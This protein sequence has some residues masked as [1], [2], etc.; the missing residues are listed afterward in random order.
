MI[1]PYKHVIVIPHGKKSFGRRSCRLAV[2]I[3]MNLIKRGYGGGVEWTQLI[4]DKL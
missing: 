2:N 3:K 1:R 4:Q